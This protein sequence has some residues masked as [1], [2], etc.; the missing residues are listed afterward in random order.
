VPLTARCQQTSSPYWAASRILPRRVDRPG[1]LRRSTCF[2]DRSRFQCV[3]PRWPGGSLIAEIRTAGGT[4]NR[5]FAVLAG[6][7]SGPAV[8]LLTAVAAALLL[9][10]RGTAPSDNDPTGSLPPSAESTR[11]AELQRQL[12]GGQTNPALVVYSRDGRPLT[13]ADRAAIAADTTALRRIALNGQ[14]PPAVF[15]EDGRAALLAV[16]LPASVPGDELVTAVDRIRAEARAG[17][18]SG[19]IAEVTG[20]AGFFADIADASPGP[21]CPC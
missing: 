16:P 19:L 18:P 7:R 11:V 17:R 9:G 2:E 1:S 20:G 21:T 6:R 12:P 5:L 8:L 10:L 14:L 4:V 13:E 15:T 3:P